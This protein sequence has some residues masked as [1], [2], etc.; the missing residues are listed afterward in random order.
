MQLKGGKKGMDCSLVLG[1]MG[2]GFVDNS[3]DSIG[4]RAFIKNIPIEHKFIVGNHDS[5]KMS[6]AHPNCLGDFGYHE[7]SGIFYLSG[8][9]SVDWKWREKDFNWWEDEQLSNDKLE[10]A[11]KLYEKV[12]PSILVAH[13]S[14]TEIKP[15]VVTNPMKYDQPTRTE[16]TLQQMIDT[17][18]PD[19]CLFG[20]HHERTEINLSGTEYI[21][22]DTLSF[23]KYADCIFEIPGIT[24]E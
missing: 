6:H 14:P 23:G 10:E 8:G 7:H 15:L 21:C 9:F 19:C 5:R 4:G 2:I 16:A 11:F 24:W 13:E 18:R 22:L 17:H 3:D 20:H 1:D 12:K